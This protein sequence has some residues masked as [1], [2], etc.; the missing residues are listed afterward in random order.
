MENEMQV[1]IKICDH[2]NKEVRNDDPD[3]KATYD[4]FTN[5]NISVDGHQL[6]RYK[7][8]YMVLCPECCEKIGLVRAPLPTNL[9]S[10]PSIMDQLYDILATIARESIQQ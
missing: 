5:I 1:T 3:Q 9:D 4:N 10:E 6:S 2:C 8:K 7:S